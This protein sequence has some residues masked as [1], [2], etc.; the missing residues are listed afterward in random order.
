VTIVGRGYPSEAEAQM[1]AKR[2]RGYVELGFAR[3]NFPADFGDRAPGGGLA[4]Y[5]RKMLEEQCDQRVLDDKHGTM[6]FEEVVWPKFVRIGSL[7]A[8]VGRNMV[9]TIGSINVAAHLDLKVPERHVLA[10]DLFS[11]SFWQPSEDA[12]FMMLMMALETL[13]EPL[14]RTDAVQAHV[15]ALISTTASSKLPESERRS[16]LGTLD[17]LKE[18]SISQA[19]R[20]LARTLGDRHYNDQTPAQF[21]TD[22][23]A[24]R[25]GLVHGRHPQ[26]SVAGR[27][28]TLEQFV[29]NLL[30]GELL[31]TVDP[32][33]LAQAGP[34]G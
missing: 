23:Y 3:V 8:T 10:Y 7:G 2:W 19:G 30:S 17:W 12:R 34:D 1:A 22:C 15:D 13:I 31:D 16:I 29:S 18:E 6:V 11:A 27:V 32:D 33:A 20:R 14:P 21:F 4:D 9:A 5:G 28:A 24:I 25:S 26:P